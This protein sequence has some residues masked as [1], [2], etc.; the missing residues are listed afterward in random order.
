MVYIANLLFKGTLLFSEDAVFPIR[1]KLTG[2][3]YS[4]SDLYKTGMVE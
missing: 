1:E 3:L 2:R 4:I